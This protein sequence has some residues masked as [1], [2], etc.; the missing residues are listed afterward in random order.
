MRKGGQDD[1]ISQDLQDN[2]QEFILFN[3]A[4]SSY[5]VKKIQWL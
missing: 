5:P 4:S 3:P 2:V 1:R